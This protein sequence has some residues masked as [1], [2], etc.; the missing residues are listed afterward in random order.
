MTQPFVRGLAGVLAAVL[1]GG[2]ATQSGGAPGKDIPTAS[3]QTEASRRAATR[4]ELASANAATLT[5]PFL[6]PATTQTIRLYATVFDSAG[7]KV[8]SAITSITVRA[9]I[10]DPRY[11]VWT[12]MNAAL[13]AGNKAAALEFLTPTAQENYSAAFDQILRIAQQIVVDGFRG[14]IGEVGFFT[15]LI[16]FL[17]DSFFLE[18]GIPVSG[19]VKLIT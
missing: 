12:N 15:I 8:K 1:V 14:D 19:F 5:Y 3:D 18:K 17:V 6:L 16:E 11:F 9:D 7:A 10:T 4:L 2:C 13:K